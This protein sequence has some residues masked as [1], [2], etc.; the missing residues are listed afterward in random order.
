MS[1]YVRPGVAER[2]LGVSRRTLLKWAE[3]GAINCI[4]PSGEGGQRLYDI[5]SVRRCDAGAPGESEPEPGPGSG[6]GP[7]LPGREIAVGRPGPSPDDWR[8]DYIYARVSTR[9]QAGDLKTQITGLQA[10]HPGALVLSDFG[11][12][13]NFKRKGLKTLLEL[14]HAGRV[15][16][17]FVAH[18]DRLCRFAYDLLEHVFRLEGAEIVVDSHDPD[19][20]SSPEIELAED[21][22]A[23]VTVFGARLY[24]RRSA[25][26]R[27]RKRDATAALQAA[28]ASEEGDGG[29]DAGVGGA[30][31]AHA[32]GGGGG[33]GP[34]AP[35]HRPHGPRSAGSRKRKRDAAAAAAATPQFAE[36][37]EEG[38]G[39]AGAHGGGGARGPDAG[40][41]EGSDEQAPEA[42]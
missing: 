13:L 33:A 17:V 30:S 14:A 8:G 21:V 3:S 23:V 34:P 38:G 15:R 32:G 27:K 28:E 1:R 22:L 4:Q 2:T 24:G 41:A 31:G 10:R 40:E 5:H 12:G 11:S 35:C 39:G 7:E 25:G 37:A 19:A 20:P 16:S 9:K 29:G 6:P 18:R 26:G 36:A 42:N